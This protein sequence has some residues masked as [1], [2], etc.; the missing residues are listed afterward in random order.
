MVPIAWRRRA[1]TPGSATSSHAYHA[2]PVDLHAQSDL[3][4]APQ[5]MIAKKPPAAQ[6]DGS[7]RGLPRSF[8]SLNVTPVANSD[9]RLST[10][11]L[12]WGRHRPP[13]PS[14][15]LMASAKP[16]RQISPWLGHALHAADA[17]VHPEDA[18]A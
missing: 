15:S 9:R 4:G 8:P 5:R 14:A 11:R 1:T 2:D 7:A 12:V 13:G 10:V 18:N 6:I 17:G 3:I 16:D